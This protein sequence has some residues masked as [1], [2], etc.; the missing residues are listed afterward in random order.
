MQDW[1]ETMVAALNVEIVIADRKLTRIVGTGNFYD[2]I[3]RNCPKDS[4]FARVIQSGDPKVNLTKGSDCIKCSNFSS[5]SEFAN[6]SYPIIVEG[7][8]I[9]V[10]SFAA[11]NE[12]QTTAMRIKKD[13]YVNMLK[14]TIEIIEREILSIKM[15]NMLKNDVT[16][17]N[18]IINCLNKGIILLNSQDEI[19]HINS[20]AIKMLDMDLSNQQVIGKNIRDF[21]HGIRLKDT[22][23]RD[24]VDYWKINDREVKILYSMNKISLKRGKSSLMIS[25]DLR[26]REEDVFLCAGYIIEK[27]CKKMNQ[28]VKKLSD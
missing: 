16:E 8:T 15:A 13:E 11:F 4:L 28:E 24:I 7:E 3:E 2:K 19:T 26:D 20:K 23:N 9:G 6:I 1:A 21:I 14:H 18:E 17:V 12:E 22:W 5:C 27:L 10:I 25:F